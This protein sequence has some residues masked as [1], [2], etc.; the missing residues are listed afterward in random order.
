MI[1]HAG[2]G[3]PPPIVALAHLMQSSACVRPLVSP[4]GRAELSPPGF[5]STRLAAVALPTVTMAADAEDKA[6]GATVTV[7][8][9][10]LGH[11]RPLAQ[12]TLHQTTDD[13]M[14][15]ASGADDA[16]GFVSLRL[17]FRK[18]RF[19]MIAHKIIILQVVIGILPVVNAV[20]AAVEVV[21]VARG[22]IVQ[23]K[24]A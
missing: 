24:D 9:H 18:V 4:I 23:A 22:R 7:S 19:Q 5:S 12:I 1:R 10:N 2:P 6:T 15:R 16:T 11:G 3:P 8:E 20:R 21:V 14:M 17:T 13:G